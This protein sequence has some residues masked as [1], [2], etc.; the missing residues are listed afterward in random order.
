W[1][2]GNEVKRLEKKTKKGNKDVVKQVAGIAGLEGRLIP[3]A[4]IIQE[5]FA[6]EQQAI[7]DSEAQVETLNAQMEELR[8]AHDSEEG[9]LNNAINDKGKISKGTVQK[10]VKELGQ[11]NADNAEEYDMLQHYKRLLEDEAKIKTKI[12][13]AIADLEILIIKKYPAL[14]LDEIKTLVVDKKWMHSMEQRIRSE[15]DNISHRLTQRIKELAERYETPLPQME[16]EVN[17]L[18]AK[19]DEH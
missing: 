2:A 18:T 11:R 6:P 5:Y 16:D 12:K 1:A 13:K 7:D 15:L 8:E 4:L 3:P 17:E 14:S 9:L 19:V 10:A